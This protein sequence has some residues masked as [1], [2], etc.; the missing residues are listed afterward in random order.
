MVIDAIAANE[1]AHN[2]I[3]SMKACRT[4]RFPLFFELTSSVSP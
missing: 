3:I 4:K 1:E 2:A